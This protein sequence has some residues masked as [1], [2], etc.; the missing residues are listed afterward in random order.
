MAKDL[1]VATREYVDGTEKV[2]EKLK[3]KV[4]ELVLEED[5]EPEHLELLQNAFGLIEASNRLIE[6]QAITICEIKDDMKELK[7][8]LA[9]K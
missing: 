8:M 1:R 7:L 3:K 9:T 4:G 2:V 6:A 5:F